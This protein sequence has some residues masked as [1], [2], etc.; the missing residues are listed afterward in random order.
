M[1]IM[2]VLIIIWSMLAVSILGLIA[3]GLLKLFK[4]VRVFIHY[5]DWY[6]NLE[7]FF[8]ILLISGVVLTALGTPLLLPIQLRAEAL[9]E[10]QVYIQENVDN[11]FTEEREGDKITI[12]W[13][14]DGW[15]QYKLNDEIK[16]ERIGADMP[17]V[18]GGWILL[19]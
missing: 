16:E 7:L 9:K 13:L 6:D 4:G 10:G 18:R 15:V 1:S 12:L 5:S 11:P 2:I 8:Q 19:E 14:K 17:I 3:L